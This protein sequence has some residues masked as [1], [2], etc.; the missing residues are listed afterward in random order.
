MIGRDGRGRGFDHIFVERLWRTVEYE[1]VY[2]HSYETVRDAVCGLARLFRLYNDEML[3]ES[4]GYKTPSEVYR[5]T[6]R[7]VSYVCKIYRLSTKYKAIF[8]LDNGENLT[9]T[10]NIGDPMKLNCEHFLT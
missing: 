8:C 6:M 1:E 7:E 4:L 2:L 5:N 3:R 9:L 10:G